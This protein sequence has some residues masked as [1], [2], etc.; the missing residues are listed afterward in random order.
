MKVIFVVGWRHSLVWLQSTA[1]EKLQRGYLWMVAA[2][3]CCGQRPQPMKLQGG[4]LSLDIIHQ[5]IYAVLKQYAM[6]LCTKMMISDGRRTVV[7]IY[8]VYFT[9]CNCKSLIPFTIWM[10]RS[11]SL[12]RIEATAF[13]KL[14]RGYLWMVAAIVR[15]GQRPL[16]IKLQ[17][18]YLW[19]VAAIVCCDQRPQPMKLQGGYLLLD[20]IHQN[21]HISHR[22]CL[23]LKAFTV[24]Y[25]LISC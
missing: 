1:F 25:M 14:Q 6:L 12:V 23:W 17:R 4:Y 10:I 18:G 3:V 5:N 9:I 20:A 2:I 16:P 11:S 22:H 24:P 8:K 19:M 21:F 13:E 7:F 15:C